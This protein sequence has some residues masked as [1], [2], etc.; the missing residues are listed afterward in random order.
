MNLDIRID[1]ARAKSA[2]VGK[3]H[4]ITPAELKAI[5]PRIAAAHKILRRERKNGDYGFWDLHKDTKVIKSVKETAATFLE[6]GYDNLV[7]LGIG[8]S[9]LGITAL[10]TALKPKYYNM[11]TRRG[12]KGCPRLF[13]MDNIDPVTFRDMM[14]ICPPK[15][16]LYNVISKSGGTAETMSQLMIVIDAI[17]KKLGKKAVKDHLVVTTNPRGKDAPPSLLH[18]VADQYKLTSFTVPLNVGGRFSVFSPVGLFPAAMLGMDIDA[19]VSGCRAMDARCAKP[20]LT[21]NPAYLRAAVQY[22]ADTEKGKVMSVMMP[23]ADGL[24]DVADWYRQIWA[25]SL[26]KRYSLDGEEVFAGQTPIKA[27]GATDQHSQVQLYREGPNDKILNILEVRRFDKTARIPDALKSVKQLAYL[28]GVTM[29]KLMAA[30]LRGTMDA[31]KISGRPV[32]RITL[33]RLN[34][35]TVAQL[36]YMLEV[37]TAMA[38]RLYNVQTFDQ[39]GVEEG[40]QIARALMG[41]KA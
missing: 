26:G 10:A 2:A 16:T 27:L 13:V 9:A 31:L 28:R 39:P 33:P 32:S 41:G 23:Y 36:L 34:A 17:E 15:K 25:E 4:G 1:V 35:H 38:G 29:N 37:E 3:D 20:S 22:L 19:M 18:P 14:R 5:E 24:R 8:G 6:R 21:E 11:M 40:K 12:R 30:E 7:I